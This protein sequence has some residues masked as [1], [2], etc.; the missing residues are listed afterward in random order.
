MTVMDAPARRSL[1]QRAKNWF[2]WKAGPGL[3]KVGE[4]LGLN[5]LTY[6]PFLYYSFNELALRN[7]PG[8]LGVIFGRFP[9]AKTVI[10]VGCGGGAFA[11]HAGGKL[12]KQVVA[13]EY[14]P[15]GRKYA[16]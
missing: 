11:A 5:W 8:V 16:K 13:C 12:G 15:H 10:D 14:S 3:S 4:K 7:A 9:D 6:N 1:P 2:L